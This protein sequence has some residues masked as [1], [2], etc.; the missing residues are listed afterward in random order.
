[1]KQETDERTDPKNLTQL[2]VQEN[3]RN[4]VQRLKSLY[5]RELVPLEEELAFGHFHDVAITSSELEAKPQVLLVGQYSTGK[6]TM[7]K[8]FIGKKEDSP[9]F[10][11]RP[12]PSTDRFVAVVHGDEEHVISGDAATC[13]SHLPYHGLKNFGSALLSKFQVLVEPAPLLEH[14][15]FV[16]TPG[17]LS[18]EKQRISRQYDFVAVTKWLAQRSDMIVLVFD[19]H[20]LDISDEFKEVIE[21]IKGNGEKIR[22]V[23][24][25]A[26][27]IDGDNL[28]KVYGALMWN[29]GKILN[30]PEVAKIHIGSFWDEAYKRRDL[31]KLLDSDRDSLRAELHDLPKNVAVRK[32]NDIVARARALKVH[33]ALVAR[34]RCE[35]PRIRVCGRRQRQERW[36]RKNLNYVYSRVTEEHGFSPC[37]MPNVDRFRERLEKFSDFSRF[38]RWDADKGSALDRL[39]DVKVPELMALIGGISHSKLRALPRSRDIVED[40]DA[41]HRPKSHGITPSL[42]MVVTAVMVLALAAGISAFTTAAGR[43]PSPAASLS[44]AP[45]TRGVSGTVTHA[46]SNGA[47]SSSVRRFINHFGPAPP[48]APP[49]PPPPPPPTS[50]AW[51]LDFAGLGPQRGVSGDNWM[52]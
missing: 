8:W 28:V 14:I 39:V 26:D 11:I 46:D 40:S 33:M 51:L 3:A 52:S 50:L 19:A 38:P 43:Q 48:V 41:P 44:P 36:L 2:Q 32:V 34:L 6:T 24:N 49:P 31:C 30:T 7:V 13:I 10:D 18:G 29:L 15:S 9:F 25:K 45:L 23:L 47:F 27:E 17:I 21:A 16:D 37:D 20:K 5:I 1:M 42:V 22:C 35:L 4:V 12:Q